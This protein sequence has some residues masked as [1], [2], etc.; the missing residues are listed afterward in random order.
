MIRTLF[1]SLALFGCTAAAPSSVAPADVPALAG[2]WWEIESIDGRPLET[3]PEGGDKPYLALVQRSYNAY[4]GC[5]WIG[6]LYAQRGDRVYTVPGPQ[7]AMGCS[8]QR[9]AQ[10]AAVNAVMFASPVVSGSGDRL[11]LKA[12]GRTI[13]LHRAQAP[14]LLEEVP[15]AWQGTR[16]ARQ[17]F[18]L[19][20]ID[21]D[22][23]NRTP[24]PRIDFAA[25]TATLRGLDGAVTTLGYRQDGNTVTFSGGKRDRL[26]DF[27]DGATLDIVSGPNGEILLAGDG[28]WLAGENVRRDRPK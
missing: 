10:E 6:G 16:L 28:H 24:F 4:A 25:T 7:T 2:S 26:G 18:D 1:A 12:V 11:E 27:F 9:A 21:G 20:R 5:N 14:R 15:E 17:S 22:P 8:G 19:S 13:A 23:L 3:A